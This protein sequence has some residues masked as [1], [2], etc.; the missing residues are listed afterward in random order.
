MIWDVLLKKEAKALCNFNGGRTRTRTLD[1]LIKRR[2]I[3]VEDQHPF[4]QMFHPS[5]IGHTIDFPFVG[6]MGLG[7]RRHEGR[8]SL[9]LYA[10]CHRAVLK[11][12]AGR[13]SNRKSARSHRPP[14]MPCFA[15]GGAPLDTGQAM[16][17]SLGALPSEGAK[18]AALIPES[19]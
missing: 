7:Q 4:R 8:L 3:S 2:V 17:R 18:V 6:K 16:F 11:W 13:R 9:G 19:L 15:A 1:P 10:S 14:L 12:D 5:C